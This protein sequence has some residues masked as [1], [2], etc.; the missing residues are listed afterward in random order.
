MFSFR[1]QPQVAATATVSWS[2]VDWAKC[3]TKQGG[4]RWKFQS[5][6]GGKYMRLIDVETGR[7]LAIQNCELP[8]P[9]GEADYGKMVVEPCTSSNKCAAPHFDRSLVQRCVSDFGF[10]VLPAEAITSL[11]YCGR[12]GGKNQQWRFRNQ[13]ETPVL[14]SA[15]PPA[16][17]AAIE[18]GNNGAMRCMHAENCLRAA[19]EVILTPVAGLTDS[20]KHWCMCD[21]YSPD[22][23]G[24]TLV[25][26]ASYC[27]ASNSQFQASASDGSIRLVDPQHSQLG[28][29]LHAAQC[30]SSSTPPCSLPSSW[31]SL[32]SVLVIAA[33]VLYHLRVITTMII[34]VRTL[35]WL[36]FIYVL[37]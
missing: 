24:G 12:C 14:L 11:I 17:P 16:G 30:S 1:Q 27:G 29:C 3:G 32:F 22:K 25:N 2:P 5:H 21:V 35:D 19:A 4:V 23:V 36:R 10:L 34:V 15:S 20:G 13:H 7:C 6:D 26:V 37:R 31:G 18:S 9:G 8:V 33:A 28:Q